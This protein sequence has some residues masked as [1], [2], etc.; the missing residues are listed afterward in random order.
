MKP[1]FIKLCKSPKDGSKRATKTPCHQECIA[2]VHDGVAVQGTCNGKNNE[3]FAPELLLKACK[4]VTYATLK[5]IRHQRIG[6]LSEI[7]SNYYN[8][9][10]NYGALM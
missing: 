8:I 9:E 4:F 10:N 3:I 7:A 1:T 5:N 2:R 6:Q